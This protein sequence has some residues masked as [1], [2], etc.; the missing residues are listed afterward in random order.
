[1]LYVIMIAIIII[2]LSENKKLSDENKRLR[3]INN[4]CFQNNLYI[5]NNSQYGY[6]KELQNSVNI[7][8][9]NYEQPKRKVVDEKLLKNNAILITGS[10]LIVLASIVFLTSSWYSIHNII[11]S[12]IIIFMLGI[13]FLSSRIAEKYLNLKQTAKAFYYI[14]L[15]YI[16]LALLS[17]S[18]FELFGKYLSFYGA[19]K[20]I[21]LAL[22]SGLVSIIYYI[23]NKNKNSIFIASFNTIFSLLFIVFGIL[24]F[25]NSFKILLIGYAIYSTIYNLFYINKNYYINP[26][27]HIKSAKLLSLGLLIF[28]MYNIYSYLMF[29]IDVSNIILNILVL[30][31]LYLILTKMMFKINIYNWIYPILIMQI[32]YN[33]SLSID[34]VF[35]VEQLLIIAASSI[36]YIFD[37]YKEKKVKWSTFIEVIICLFIIFLRTDDLVNEFVFSKE[38]I[39]LFSLIFTFINYFLDNKN[40]FASS[41][42]FI[43]N[44]NLF[45]TVS[46]TE[47]PHVLALYLILGIIAFSRIINKME[48]NLRKAINNI[49]NIF[50]CYLVFFIE[51]DMFYLLFTGIYTI[52]NYYIGHTEKKI[53]Y[54]ILS[55]V[56]LNITLYNTISM[57]NL[58]IHD[59]VVPITSF[60]VMLVESFNMCEKNKVLK[61]YIFL[62]FI[63]SFGLLIYVNEIYSFLILML[64]NLCYLKYI[65]DYQLNRNFM[66]IPHLTLL[67][68]IYGSNILI[69]NDYNYMYI[70]SLIMLGIY[71]YLIYQKKENQ[72]IIS[73][74]IYA[75]SHIFILENSSYMNHIILLIGLIISYIFKEGKIKELFK[76]MTYTILLSLYYVLIDDLSLNEISI[77]TK[78]ILFVYL[79]LITRTVLKKYITDYK[80]FEYFGGALISLYALSNYTNEADGI[81]FVLGL[82]LLLVISYIY[83]FGPLF[84]ISI[85]FIIFNLLILTRTF[86]LSIPWWIYIL[87]IGTILIIFAIYN[88]MKEK[89]SSVLK[90]K[91]ENIKKNLDM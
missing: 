50:I 14:A 76:S 75:I 41:C 37:I 65:K 34:S 78:G 6:N 91:F 60:I 2:L 19:G 31:N 70:I 20:Y 85:I 61:I 53:N 80:F 33:V 43:V 4:N 90:E 27:Y 68:F 71:L 67:P 17:I 48:I 86:W 8:N 23:C 40:K 42:F 30:Y 21:Y 24:H 56:F 69:F 9:C 57:L 62:Q 73:Y 28:S 32:A 89:E 15:M 58:N 36:L 29:S 47:L 10:I 3:G 74:F 45:I 66:Y 44:L 55:Y 88:E 1:M 26:N 12:L 22:S 18:I 84:V 49:G 81:I 35:A 63:I 52:I 87:I 16:P 72:F 46:V 13:F 54:R 7:E 39:L 59:L 83:K 11:K 64:L 38:L 79:L 82:V 5:N 51:L 25:T 77:F